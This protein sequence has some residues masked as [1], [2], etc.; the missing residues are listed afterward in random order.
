MTWLS[1][2]TR[3]SAATHFLH[4][5]GRSQRLEREH[6]NVNDSHVCRMIVPNV[7]DE[8]LSRD[9][10]LIMELQVENAATLIQV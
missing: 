9:V 1:R 2:V 5:V 8:E 6:H 7:S 10:N 3:S 4:L